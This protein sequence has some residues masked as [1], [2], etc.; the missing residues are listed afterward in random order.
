MAPAEVGPHL[1][2]PVAEKVF[3]H[4]GN[5]HHD[6]QRTGRTFPVRKIASGLGISS[7]R[8]P[9]FFIIKRR[10]H[11]RSR[12]LRSNRRTSH[13]AE[14]LLLRRQSP[15]VRRLLLSSGRR[16]DT[17]FVGSRYQRGHGLGSVLGD[18]FRRFVI[19]LF[20]T[21]GKTLAL[22]AL[23]T[24]MDVAEDV[25]GG[26]SGLKESVKKRVPGGIKRTA[27]SLIDQSLSLIHI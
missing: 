5:R 1:V 7:Y 22:D 12:H 16:G 26:K 10:M 24:G 23:R 2:R 14:R 27:R 15:H 8:S 6:R 9:I 18:L 17:R 20:M 13:E 19:L 11:Y 21:H 3:R 25:L 4:R